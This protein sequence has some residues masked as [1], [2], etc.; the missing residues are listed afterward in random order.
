MIPTFIKSYEAAADVAGH[1]I[2][3][4]A[5]PATDQMVGTAASETDACI[6]VSDRLGADTGQMLDVHRGGLV[7]VQLGGAVQAGDPLTSDASGTAVVATAQ[8][9][10]T[11]RIVGYADEPGVAGDIIDFFFAPGVIHQG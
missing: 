2:V 6:G 4:F 5:T 3:K 1:R 7:S 11:V 10:T 8:A 9:A